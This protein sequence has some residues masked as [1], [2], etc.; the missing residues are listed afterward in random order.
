MSVG[1]TFSDASFNY[2]I[3]YPPNPLTPP[4]YSTITDSSNITNIIFIDNSIHDANLF[5]NSLSNDTF[6]ILY[7]YNTDSSHILDFLKNT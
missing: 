7:N 4:I 2:T 3:N 5:L 1:D 6:A